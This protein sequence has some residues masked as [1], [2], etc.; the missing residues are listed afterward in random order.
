MRKGQFLD[1]LKFFSNLTL[2]DALKIPKLYPV[3]TV[4]TV[5]EV[6]EVDGGNGVHD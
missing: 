3:T 6:I 1:I 4:T 2:L 5:N